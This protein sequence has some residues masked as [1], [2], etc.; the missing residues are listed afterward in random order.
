MEAE[1]STDSPSASWRPRKA[2]GVVLVQSSRPE[3]LGNRW[4]KSQ[5]ESEGLRIRSSDVQGQGKIDVPAQGENR[6]ALPLLFC[7]VQTLSGLD[8]AH[9]HW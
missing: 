3:N 8:D 2:S 4:Y 7:S 5:F 6:F 1:S 9:Q